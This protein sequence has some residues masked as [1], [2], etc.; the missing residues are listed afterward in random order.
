MDIGKHSIN[1]YLN[2]S[3]DVSISYPKLESLMIN[4]M[5]VLM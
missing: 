3:P 2:K 1:Y 5:N 4:S